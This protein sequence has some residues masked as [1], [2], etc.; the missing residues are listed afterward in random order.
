MQV[1]VILSWDVLRVKI[2]GV[3]DVEIKKSYLSHFTGIG[4]FGW[5]CLKGRLVTFNS[6]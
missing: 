3:L 2:S 5:D 1:E 6:S 4:R